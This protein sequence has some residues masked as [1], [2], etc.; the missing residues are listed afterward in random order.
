VGICAGAFLA[1]A[2]YEPSRS[3]GLLDAHAL[4]PWKRG[5]AL[6]Q[7]EFSAEGA[8][9]LLGIAIGDNPQDCVPPCWRADNGS[10][11]TLLRYHNGPLII[12]GPRKI[13][14][15]DSASGA[16]VTKEPQQA[17]EGSPTA[18]EPHTVCP[19]KYHSLAIFA[20]DAA[21]R[22]SQE[23]DS[24]TSLEPQVGKSA[25]G[26][27]RFG[28]GQVLVISSHAESTHPAAEAAGADD[29][30]AHLSKS[31]GV[32]AYGRLIQRAVL[33]A[34]G[35]SHPPAPKAITAAGPAASVAS[36]S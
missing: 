33:W 3:L 9:L 23:A 19:G 1:L 25:I 28:H 20:G 2:H 21:C 24:A 14:P 15:Q 13:T 7:H 27:G 11:R 8:A 10:W 16:T 18:L 26:F 32:P 36:D 22:E 4:L 17:Q 31:A 6:L 5:H 34:A 12:P 30:A 29:P 35:T